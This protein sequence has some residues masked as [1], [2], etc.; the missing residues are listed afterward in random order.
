MYESAA[1]LPAYIV[2]ANV[3]DGRAVS[4]SWPLR[5]RE[6]RAVQNRETNY[7]VM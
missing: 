3:D 4:T 1:D 2:A 7:F 5:A 6:S